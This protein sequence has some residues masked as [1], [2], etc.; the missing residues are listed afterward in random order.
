MS[1]PSLSLAGR[2]ALV[3]GA[4]RGIGAA[5]AIA[6]AEAG[7][8]VAIGD[9][10]VSTGELSSVAEAIKKIGRRTLPVQVDVSKKNDVD[11]MV[12]KVVSEFDTID[13]LVNNAGVGH[14]DTP[15]E[16]ET[17]DA[18]LQGSAERVARIMNESIITNTS[19]EDWE[20]TLAI[21]LGG[22][23][24]CSQAVSKIM[25]EKK[26]GSIINISSV[27][28]FARGR[29]LMSPYNI[30]KR[31]IVWFTEGLASDLAKYHIRVNAI[32][33]GGIMTEMM[34]YIWAFPERLKSI[35]TNMPLSNALLPP[36]ACA[37]AA[38]FFASD[39]SEFITGQTIIVDAGLSITQP[40]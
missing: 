1:M 16:P 7:A 19:K 3:T 9:L 2:V 21:N 26:Q 13:I 15:D 36:S 35:E 4:R 40:M 17:F 22:C 23:Y 32:A 27:M 28:A 14:G 12:Q 30:S 5:I 38:L 18:I 11:Q 37:K 34:R 29:S 25:I 24:L 31:G 8:D 6:F 33:P 10:V 39:L 20:K